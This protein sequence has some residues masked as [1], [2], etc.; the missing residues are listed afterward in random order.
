MGKKVGQKKMTITWPF[1]PLKWYGR[2]VA[3]NFS[4]LPIGGHFSSLFLLM[5]YTEMLPD[6][7]FSAPQWI[8]LIH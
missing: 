1:F 7:H 5:M 2:I 4:G 3:G 8:L 6:G